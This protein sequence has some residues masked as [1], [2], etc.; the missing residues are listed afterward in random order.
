MKTQLSQLY[1]DLWIIDREEPEP[2]DKNWLLNNLFSYAND[3][4]PTMLGYVDNFYNIYKRNKQLQTNQDVD[5]YISI[6]EKKNV[7]TQINILLG[8]LR[9]DERNLFCYSYHLFYLSNPSNDITI[10]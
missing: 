2:E 7:S 6:L 1:F 8:L 10:P 3:F 9:P 5:K 4:N